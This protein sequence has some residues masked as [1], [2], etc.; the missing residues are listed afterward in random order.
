MRQHKLLLA[1]LILLLSCGSDQTETAATAKKQ[2]ADAEL[3]FEKMAAEKGMA[4]A[5][6]FYAD[7]NAVIK[8]Q[9]DT[10]IRGKEQI[11]KYYSADFY[12][13]ASV[14]WSP[15]FIEVGKGGDLGYSYGKY[16]WKSRDSSGRTIEHAGIFHTVWKRQ[17][18]GSWKYVWD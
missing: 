7:S 11:S 1:L 8:R 12:R 4:E 5:F 9:N 2:I 17:S 3:S 15:D 14:T 13:S 6:A 10:L 16:L 18:D